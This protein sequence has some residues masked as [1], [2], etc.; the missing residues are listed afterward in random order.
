[1]RILAFGLLAGLLAFVSIAKGQYYGGYV[2]NRAATPGESYARGLSDMTRSQSIA[3]LNNS[4]AAINMT[5]AARKGMENRQQW[6][7][8]YFQMRDANRQYRAQE[9]GPKA[10]MEDA[11]RY[12]QLG[13]PA[14]LSPSELDTV[15]GAISWPMLLQS[16]QYADYRAQL[17]SLYAK[18]AEYGG[19]TTDDYFQ[20]NR[21]TGAMLD[22]LKTQVRNVPPAEYMAARRFIESLA[23]EARRPAG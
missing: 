11:V 6:T 19:I 9:R 8:T 20:I 15:D 4:E 22:A 1:M 7:D 18:R 2:D 10:T 3:N 12:A 16:P 17:E 23:Y 21:T 5:E 13:K 14:A